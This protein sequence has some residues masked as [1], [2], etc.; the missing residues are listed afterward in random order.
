M[1]FLVLGAVAENPIKVIGC[2]SISTSY[3]NFISELNSM[4]TKIRNE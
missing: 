3:P 4:G 2:N 1:S